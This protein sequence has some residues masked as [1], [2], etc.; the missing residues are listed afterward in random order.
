MNAI[1]ELLKKAKRANG[2]CQCDHCRWIKQYV[3]QALAE[4]RTVCV[5]KKTEEDYYYKT[6]CGHYP[7]QCVINDM[8]A[9]RVKGCPWCIKRI[10]EVK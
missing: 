5:W 1:E 6:A 8:K 10:K 2:N 9:D 4:A 3:D 7:C